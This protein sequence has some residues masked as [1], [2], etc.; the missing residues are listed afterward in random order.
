MPLPPQSHKYVIMTMLDSAQNTEMGLQSQ[1]G[2]HRGEHLP[3]IVNNFILHLPCA[4]R[5]PGLKTQWKTQEHVY[6]HPC[7]PINTSS[8]SVCTL[9]LLHVHYTSNLHTTASVITDPLSPPM[10]IVL[11]NCSEYMYCPLTTLQFN[12]R[13]Q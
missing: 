4:P 3:T 1:Y 13:L 5:D 9:H 11:H 6:L 10:M 8:V 12:Y 2:Q 7:F